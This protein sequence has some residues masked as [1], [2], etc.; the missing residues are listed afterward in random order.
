M[1]LGDTLMDVGLVGTV[2]FLVTM[3]LALVHD[4]PSARVRAWGL[5]LCLLLMVVASFF[6][7]WTGPPTMGPPDF[8]APRFP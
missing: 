8:R 1:T 5:G 6:K 2:Y 4:E 3:L 7:P